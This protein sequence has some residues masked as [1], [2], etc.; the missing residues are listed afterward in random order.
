MNT[1]GRHL[2]RRSLLTGTAPAI[3]G[4]LAISLTKQGFAR[5]GGTRP[6]SAASG[7][8]KPEE[9]KIWSHEYWANK[10]DN[11]KLYMFRKRLS[12]PEAGK[13]PLPV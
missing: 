9:G 10:G 2:S 6:I 3:A 8:A 13:A 1:T 11:V 12:A 5:P 7:A 4:G